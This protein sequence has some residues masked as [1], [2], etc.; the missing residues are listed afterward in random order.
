MIARIQPARNIS[1]PIMPQSRQIL[2]DFALM[3]LSMTVSF[4]TFW[5]CAAQ[6][7]DPAALSTHRRDMGSWEGR[8]DVASLASRNKSGSN[9]SPRPAPLPNPL[10]NSIHAP[11]SKKW[12]NTLDPAESSLLGPLHL[13]GNPRPVGFAA[14]RTSWDKWANQNLHLHNGLTTRGRTGS[15]R[16]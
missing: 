3:N 9:R 7:S 5:W 8:T 11:F 14:R 12:Y 4:L 1:R 13:H 16:L 10:L 2:R 6:G 15:T